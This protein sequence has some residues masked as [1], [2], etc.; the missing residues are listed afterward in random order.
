MER[1]DDKDL[2]YI[3]FTSGSTGKPKGVMINRLGFVN[4]QDITIDYLNLSSIS[5]I[6]QSAPVSFDISV[7]Q[8]ICPLMVGG[9]IDIIDKDILID[10]QK[11]LDR[12][13]KDKISV[14]ETVPSLINEYLDYELTQNKRVFNNVKVISTGEGIAKKIATKWN[15]RYFKNPLINAYGPAEASDDT[16]FFELSSRAIANNRDIPIGAP[17]NNIGTLVL[18][19]DGQICPL[20]IV[21]EICI[22]GIS[23]ANGYINNAVKTAESFRYAPCIGEKIYA[24][25]DYGRWVEYGI[26]GYNGRRDNQIKIRGQRAE[27]GEIEEKIRQILN[28]E[29]VSVILHDFGN[30]KRLVCFIDIL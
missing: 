2:T 26:L 14:L 12:I 25:G 3:I 21:G 18:D 28:L 22:Y 27:L 19:C 9:M 24:T 20:K 4:H 23:L 17:L 29:K 16:H 5:V 7:W 11:M 8:L 15:E 30:N 6:A 1:V 10:P 13:S